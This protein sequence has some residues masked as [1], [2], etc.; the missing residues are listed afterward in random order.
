M[1]ETPGRKEPPPSG[2]KTLI[3]ELF[4]P[5]GGGFSLSWVLY[6]WTSDRPKSDRPRIGTPVI[7]GASSGIGLV[8][9]RLAA[10]VGAKLV[11]AARSEGPL[12]QLTEEI[13]KAGGKAVYVVADVGIWD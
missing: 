13:T 3:S 9:A 11:L 7:T 1:Y 6:P 8:T 10:K 12:R 4:R 5:E 2:R